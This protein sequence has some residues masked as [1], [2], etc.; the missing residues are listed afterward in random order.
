[1]LPVRNV[2]EKSLSHFL[3]RSDGDVESLAGHHCLHCVSPQLVELGGQ[4]LRCPARGREVR[5]LSSGLT[6]LLPVASIHERVATLRTLHHLG[7][8]VLTDEM[9][10]RTLIYWR[11]VGRVQTHRA[12]Q[13]VHQ[14][15]Y[16][17]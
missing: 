7:I 16:P 17:G 15:L 11:G 1:M 5:L 2:T 9:A 10:L 8:A 13:C 12:L 3:W 6:S 4:Q 14:L